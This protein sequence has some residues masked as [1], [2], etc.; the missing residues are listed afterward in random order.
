MT[1][2]E[3]G[4]VDAQCADLVIPHPDARV[5]CGPRCDSIVLAQRDD[6]LFKQTNVLFHGAV[7][8]PE[9]QNGI[10]HELSGSMKCDQATAVRLVK[11]CSEGL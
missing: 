4:G 11:L 7:K 6:G 1:G 8:V 5:L 2:Y 9:I 10:G 3:T